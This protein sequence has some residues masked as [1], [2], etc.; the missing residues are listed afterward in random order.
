MVV[1]DNDS[2]D[3]TPDLL[4][5]LTHLR[6]LR[7]INGG[8]AHGINVGME[9]TPEAPAWRILNPDLRLAPGSARTL[10][11]SLEERVGII[12]PKVV[13]SEGRLVPSMR[14]RP[15]LLRALG[16]SDRPAFAE[17]VVAPEEYEI[18]QDA[19]WLLG[20]VLLVSRECAVEVGAW[21]ESFF[22]YSEETDFCLR[23][24]AAGWHTR[25]Q[26]RAYAVHTGG[27]SGRSGR[28]HAMQILNRVRLYT[29]AH[30]G[31]ASSAYY[32]IAVLSGLPMA[33]ARQR[34]IPC[35]TP[36]P[37]PPKSSTTRVWP[38]A[39]S[40]PSLSVTGAAMAT[41]NPRLALP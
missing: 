38:W 10:L 18:T 21:D 23:A 27:G 5:H 32:A 33:S 14:R 19:D 26:P 34:G 29:R 41:Q 39:W 7:T 30:G 20:A 17:Y 3:G 22:L 36:G 1:V 16:L 8:Y 12:G 2:T 25:Y 24:A 15:T 9:N 28:T 13:D 11:E 6:V 31:I 37:P 35:L 40:H 4:S